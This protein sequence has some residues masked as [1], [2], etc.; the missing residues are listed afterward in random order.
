MKQLDGV[1]VY[2]QYCFSDKL[3]SLMRVIS[4]LPSVSGCW[5]TSQNAST[6]PESAS[7]E[8]CLIADNT[9]KTWQPMDFTGLVS[10]FSGQPAGVVSFIPAG[11]VTAS[12]AEVQSWVVLPVKCSQD[13]TCLIICAL[14]QSGADRH[15]ND[16]LLMVADSL[17]QLYQSSADSAYRQQM[18]EEISLAAQ[19]GGW[20]YHVDRQQ[21][22]WSPQTFRF[23][24]IY[25]NGQTDPL[26]WPVTFPVT[27]R[28]Q[29]K[30]FIGQV[31]KGEETGDAEV[32]YLTG[33][34]KQRWAR[35]SARRGDNNLV[36]GT[37]KD[38]SEQHRLSDTEHNF[39]VYLK[40]IL[41]NLTD[42]V[43]TVD[44]TG[45]IITVNNAA[46]PTF[47]YEP[48]D[49]LGED[50][51]TVMP[52]IFSHQDTVR[53]I[54][55]ITRKGGTMHQAV[56]L[57]ANKQRFPI[58][59]SISEIV[60]DNFQQYVVIVRDITERKQ[61]SDEI[62]RMA[63]YDEVTGLPNLKSFERDV[64]QLLEQTCD[65][66]QEIYCALMDIDKFS[67]LNLM[68]GKDVGDFVLQQLASRIE[69]TIS[70]LFRIY[71]GHADR[72]FIL[73]SNGFARQDKAMAE[74]INE[75]EW[76]LHNDVL[77]EMYINSQAHQVS[78]SLSSAVIEP[79]IA[80]YEKVVGILE[81]GRG[82]AKAQGLAGKIAFDRNGFSDYERH[83]LIRQAFLTSMEQNEFFLVL[84]PQYDASGGVVCSEA[85]LRWS[86]A[87][88]GFI[89]PAEFIP[90]AEE[91]DVIVDIGYWV[92]NEACRIL[93]HCANQQIA[94]RIAVNISGRH[95][96]QADFGERLLQIVEKW[97]V[98]PEQLQ[99]ELTE[100]TLVTAISIVRERMHTLSSYGFAFS[101]DD[102][103]TG[104]S[105]LSYLKELP[106][107]ELKI[108]RYFVDEINISGED[109][110]IVNTIIDMAQAMGVSTVAEGIENDI[111]LQY[112]TERGCDIFQGFFLSRP[113]PVDDW[114]SVLKTRKTG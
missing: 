49:L 90:I 77:A 66:R 96:A 80:S 33:K 112:L 76:L 4:Q 32:L 71:R 105:S 30:L 103:G 8:F 87:S 10:L 83:N 82:R 48:V 68:L 21:I 92:L 109:V 43:L 62:Y 106:I 88:L 13:Q 15:I 54:K 5:L 93:A 11:Q 102:F 58:E 26:R 67:Q 1:V 23:F 52:D 107:S 41:D 70:P 63:Y 7:A 78:A 31:M 97:G 2:P 40:A 50:I 114:I 17:R 74:L 69:K 84:Q 28:M 27:S 104:Y 44:D 22:E 59:V 20:L 12:P 24:G 35:F 75:T 65:V 91:S 37:I 72:F 34:G 42:A 3:S 39:T 18:L 14:N 94:T 46:M 9:P 36:V 51:S 55:R 95:I 45:M 85:L 25:E 111:Q 56:A 61:A 99:L 89:S 108:D 6:S 60:Q 64:K 79:H 81:F 38:V 53:Q 113:I 110:P 16:T 57:H 47:G 86:H 29:L 98:R 19:T 101:I 100:T 73:Y